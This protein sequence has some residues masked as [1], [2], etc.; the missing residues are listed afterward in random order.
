MFPC[1]YA[2]CS[3]N[4]IS[5]NLYFE[6]HKDTEHITN[7]ET[8]E[9]FSSVSFYVKHDREF[10]YVHLKSKEITLQQWNKMQ[11]PRDLK[12]KGKNS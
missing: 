7:A 3:L 9:H 1:Y 5:I 12:Q 4:F 11:T 8:G 10:Y 2:L 6:E